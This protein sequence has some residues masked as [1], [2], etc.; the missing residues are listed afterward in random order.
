MTDLRAL[1]IAV[2]SG[3][4]SNERDISLLSGKSVTEALTGLGLNAVSIDAKGGFVDKL[5][6]LGIN[7]AFIALHGAFGEDGRIQS[8]LKSEGIPF[9]GSS[10]EACRKSMDKAESRRCFKE[11]GLK[12]P[13]GRILRSGEKFPV[14][15]LDF[16]LFVKPA[17]G[18]SSIGVTLVKD[19]SALPDAI[20]RG[21][22]E[23][24]ELVL[25]SKVNGREFTVGVL[26]DKTLP[27]IEIKTTRDFYDYSAKYEDKGTRYDEPSDLDEAVRSE[28]TDTAFKAHR[29]L[30]CSVFSRV[31]LIY[32]E[33]GPVVLELNAIPGLSPRSLL[34][35]MAQRAGIEFG[36]LCLKMIEGSL[37]KDTGG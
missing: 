17:S 36:E 3:G 37:C 12:I 21:F 31:D 23:S 32:N 26:G 34:P 19:R 7:F 18:G 4:E 2:L 1:N 20:K 16:P 9:S 22:E 24:E 14:D 13:D 8:L 30:G 11:A 29:A 6:N 27:M 15:S 10:A 28:I 5:K 35:K 33:M 25:D